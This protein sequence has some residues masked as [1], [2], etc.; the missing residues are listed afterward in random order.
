M[1][2]FASSVHLH[3]RKRNNTLQE[4]ILPRYMCKKS[5]FVHKGYTFLQRTYIYYLSLH[6]T[7]IPSPSLQP[8]IYLISINLY[9]YIFPFTF[10]NNKLRSHLHTYKYI[11]TYISIYLITYLL[12]T[13]S[14]M[15]YKLSSITNI[16]HSGHLTISYSLVCPHLVYSILMIK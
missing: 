8:F 9:I 15:L 2:S 12:R 10:I 4:L 3:Q 14:S 11:Y 16:Y 6:L 1:K 13:V 5:T 7:H